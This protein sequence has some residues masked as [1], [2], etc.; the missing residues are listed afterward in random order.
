MTV[1][2]VVAAATMTG[3][4]GPDRL[5]GGGELCNEAVVSR[6]RFCADPRSSIA[7]RLHSEYLT[8]RAD[9]EAQ[10]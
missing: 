9:L 4:D 2:A 8:S 7:L 5:R 1:V 10:K 3:A 6:R